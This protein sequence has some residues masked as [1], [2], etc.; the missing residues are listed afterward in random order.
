M[1]NVTHAVVRSLDVDLLEVSWAIDDIVEDVYDYTF[2]IV[3]SESPMG[4]YEALSV[5]FQDRY[6]FVDNRVHPFSLNRVLFYKILVTHK[7]TNFTEE[8]GPYSPEPE[9]D[10]ITLELRRHMQL[11]YREFTGRR[12]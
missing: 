5:P 10:L 2:Q 8:F 12:C 1:L 7:P 9:A 4:P 11:L 3:R 6:I